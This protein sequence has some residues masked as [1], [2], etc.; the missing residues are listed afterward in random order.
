MA[1]TASQR[2][3][4]EGLR[5]EGNK[6][7]G[8][9][10]FGAAI[11]RY[12]E[13]ITLD[14]TSASLF[15]N[16]ALCHKKQGADWGRVAADARS[17]LALDRNHVKAHYLLGRWL[18]RLRG[19]RGLHACAWDMHGLGCRRH[20]PCSTPPTLQPNTWILAGVAMREQGCGDLRQ[21]I[22]HLSRALE[23][24]RAKDDAIKDEIW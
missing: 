5:D 19:T 3:A 9:G 20:M 7:F 12:T 2:K 13:A 16:R 15:V 21:S 11:D 14:P 24:A 10:R 22:S 8:K 17:A 6:L 4:A 18:W 23:E 1:P